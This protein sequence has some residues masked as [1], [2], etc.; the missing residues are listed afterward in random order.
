MKET[1]AAGI[2]RIMEEQKLTQAEV[3][4]RSGYTKQQFNDMLQGRKRILADYLPRIAEAMGVEPGEIFRKADGN[5]ILSHRYT[6][7]IVGDLES[8][9]ELAV[10]S[11]DLV[12]TASDNIVVK[13]VPKT[14]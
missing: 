2:R 7:I 12:T 13:L 5:G 4:E 11:E 6:R 9:K 3:A 1:A 14:G 8:K 10:I